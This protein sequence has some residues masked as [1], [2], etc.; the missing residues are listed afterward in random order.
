MVIYDPLNR[1]IPQLDPD[2]EYESDDSDQ[3]D[4][5]IKHSELIERLQ[6][7]QAIQGTQLKTP[8]SN[9]MYAKLQGLLEAHEKECF[10]I[11]KQIVHEV[12]DSKQ[13]IKI[14]DDPNILLMIRAYR[15][16]LDYSI[17]EEAHIKPKQTQMH[18]FL[19]EQQEIIDETI[20][21]EKK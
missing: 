11:G 6:E 8:L 20:R 4:Q 10:S 16:F 19:K 3:E 15:L 18:A 9:E 17:I 2:V 14:K 13:P 12:K 7:L 1:R 5:T 21:I